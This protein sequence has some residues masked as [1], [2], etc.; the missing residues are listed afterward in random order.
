MLPKDSKARREKQKAN[1]QTRLD[2]HLEEIP[3][4]TRVVPYSDEL[5]RKTAIEW[6]V[7]TDQVRRSSLCVA[8]SSLCECSQ[9]MH[10]PTQ[11][12]GN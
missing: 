12:F 9:L 6:L 4:K 11:S 2:A 8:N 10:L 7:V 3:A 1:S 5:F